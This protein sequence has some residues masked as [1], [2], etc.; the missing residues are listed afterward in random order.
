[1]ADKSSSVVDRLNA[2]GLSVKIK[3]AK[4]SFSEM[5]PSTLKGIALNGAIPEETRAKALDALELK[6]KTNK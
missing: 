3:R 2:L 5:E 6:M 1:M 4:K